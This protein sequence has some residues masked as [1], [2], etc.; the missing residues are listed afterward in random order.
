[1]RTFRLRHHKYTIFREILV[2]CLIQLVQL[3]CD[4]ILQF[5]KAFVGILK[6]KKTP[7][8]DSF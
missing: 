5:S 6:K 7:A 3:T 4:A 8:N 1:M 2:K